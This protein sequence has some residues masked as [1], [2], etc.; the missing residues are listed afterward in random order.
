MPHPPTALRSCYLGTLTPTEAQEKIGARFRV[1]ELRPATAPD[2]HG[3]LV[4][5]TEIIFEAT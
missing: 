4:E 1:L 5:A 3:K 2:E